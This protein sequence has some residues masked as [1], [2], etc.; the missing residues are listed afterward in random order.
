MELK[1]NCANGATEYESRKAA[2][3]EETVAI[4]ETVKILNDDDALDLFKKT[5]PSPSLI[6]VTR[7][8]R[9]LRDQALLALSKAKANGPQMSFIALA[10]QGK[11]VGF[12][13]VLKMIDEMV[14]TLGQEQK[15][16]DAQREWCLKEFDTSEDKDKDLKR[17]IKNLETQIAETEE[18]IATL[19]DELAAL[20]AGIKDLDK[21]V[22][23]ATATRKEENALFVQTAAENNAALQLLDVAKNRLNKFYNP[24]VYKPPPKRELT[25]EERLYVASGGVLDPTPAPGGIAG[26]GIGNPLA[27][28]Q[29]K[30]RDA[31]PPPPETVDAYTKRDSSGP[32][33]LIDRL[34]NDLQKETQENEHDEEVAQKEYEEFMTDSALKRQADSKSITE[35]EAQKAELEADLMAA[36]DQKETST[37]ELLATEQY[38]A[39][40]HGSCDF[41]LANFDLRKEAR[42]SEKEALQRAKAVLSGADYSFRQVR[43]AHFLS[44]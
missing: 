8:D 33:A 14:V 23:Q 22:A 20:E 29:T 5:L 44:K 19:T 30:M 18:G 12:E 35:K 11:K 16:D 6:Q 4:S 25:E 10:L 17:A 15:D 9:D 24:A 2:R 7:S 1:K 43:V 37:K 34:K 32:I 26:T 36:K 3:A 41:L 40:L 39:Q 27:F 21:M 42:A 31:P 28:V 13:K 38:I